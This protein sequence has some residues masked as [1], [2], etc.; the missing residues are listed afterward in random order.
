MKY[1]QPSLIDRTFVDDDFYR[2]NKFTLDYV[3]TTDTSAHI[4]EP[5]N[6]VKVIHTACGLYRVVIE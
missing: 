2:N 3:L 1:Y 5:E 4:D 6:L